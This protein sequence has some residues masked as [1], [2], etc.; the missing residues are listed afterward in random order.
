MTLLIRPEEKTMMLIPRLQTPTPETRQTPALRTPS[1]PKPTRWALR[2]PALVAAL[3]LTAVSTTPG[4]GAEAPPTPAVAGTRTV[5]GTVTD[6]EGRPVAGAEVRLRLPGSGDDVG[7]AVTDP[8]GRF[9]LEARGPRAAEAAEAAELLLIVESPGFLADT[10]TVQPASGGTTAVQIELAPGEFSDAITVHEPTLRELG[11]VPGGTALV[12]RR[13]IE[14]SRAHNLADVLDFVPGVVA[15]SRWGADESRLSI[16]GSG[17]R[18]N[19]HHR[20][21]NLLINGIPY[22]DADGF[23]DFETLDLLATERIEVWKGANAL[24]YGGNSMGGAVNF[25][26]YTGETAAPLAV[27]A[28]GG[29]YG[30]L[31]AQVAASGGSGGARYYLSA[32]VTGQDGYRE[33]SEQDRG[34]VFANLSWDVGERTEVFTDFIYADVE[35]KLP[36]SLT[37]AE[38][39]ADPR[40]ADP[41]NVAQDYGRFYSYGRLGFGVRHTLGDRHEV[42]AAV[43]GQLRDMVHPIFQVLDQDARSFGGELR[44]RFTGR[45]PVSSLVVGLSPQRGTIDE[46]RFTNVGGHSGGLVGRF[47]TEATNVG[48]YAEA[49]LSWNEALTLVL[50]ARGD[51]A[52]RVFD[53]RFP[54]DGDRSDRRSYSALSPKLGVLWQTRPSLQVFANLSRSYEPPLLLELTS[55]GAPG[56]LDLEAQD[57]WQIEVGTRGQAHGRI[58]WDVAVFDAEIDHE[59][60]NLNRRP[61]PGAPFTIP[62][63]RNAP[64]TRHRGLE[65]GL[66]TV[67]ARDLW[68]DGDR[69]GWRTAY[70]WSDFRFV[71]D[72]DFGNNRLPG[73]PRHLL[74]SELRYTHP[75][76]WWVAPS[77]EGSPASYWVDSANT[78]DNEPYTVLNMEIGVTWRSAEL[79]VQAA[80]LTG[81]LYSGSLQVDSANG[82]F[83]EPGLDRSFSVGLRWKR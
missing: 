48:L 21:L 43:H 9:R 40:Q 66:D 44:Y 50:G 3:V 34:R 31:K 23:S 61:F 46:R 68:S 5:A 78:V 28:E 65:L 45:G 59:L 42:T 1:P 8:E 2:V 25:V 47:G 41:N 80:N 29:S 30:L 35:E 76:Q 72:P 69:L 63:Y 56:F 81:E 70:T 26:T 6:L 64:Q 20:G 33:H 27:T 38:F 13:E 18:N 7:G 19:F 49:D 14:Q 22:G 54:A 39:E 10:F 73:A 53:D 58:T 36:G 37:R 55:F 16:R 77:L 79:F 15:Q 62:S 11:R 74:K 52:E 57:T 82:R 17:L 51:R 67:L 4:A 12:E 83:F 24:R 32:S 60:I 75:N 71:D